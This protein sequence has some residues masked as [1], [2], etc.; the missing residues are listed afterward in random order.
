MGRR[1][2]RALSSAE[3]LARR[4]LAPR[5]RRAVR[6]VRQLVPARR[7]SPAGRRAS[8]PRRS[9]KRARC[10]AARDCSTARRSASS[11][12]SGPMRRSFSISCTWAPCRRSRWGRRATVCC[13]TRT[14]SSWTTASSRAWAS[15]HYWV[16][17]TSAGVER[18]AA[19]FEEWLQC[20]YTQLKVLITPVTSRWGNVTVAGPR[21]WRMAGSGRIR[22]ALLAALDAA[23]DDARAAASMGVPLRVLR[24]SFSGELGYEINLPAD[25]VERAARAAVDARRGIP[26][27]ALRH[28]GA[29]D[30]AHRERLHPYRHGHRRHHACRAISAWH[31]P[32][33]ASR[34]I[35]SGAARCCV[36]RRAIPRACSW[37]RC[38]PPTG[39]RGCRSAGR[40]RPRRRRP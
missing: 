23:H 35:S 26:G 19:A 8:N 18:T 32:S 37:S 6:A 28:R 9:A 30:P 36:P 13:S 15:R 40:S 27:R 39:A 24:A 10:A 3:A 1:T 4:G 29:G 14:G 38:R 25:H 7:V 16:N 21:A 5:A 2:R 12:Y 31:A 22:R 33:S 20:E 17:T 11:R 34:R